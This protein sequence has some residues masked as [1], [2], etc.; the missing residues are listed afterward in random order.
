MNHFSWIDYTIFGVYLAI[1][2]G[3]GLFA[4]RGPKTSLGEYFLAGRGMNSV[5]VAMSILAALFS[6]ISY[7]AGPAE[8]YRN[9]FGFAYAMLAFFIATPFTAIWM[10]PKFYQSR[11]FTAYQ[12]L[13]ERFSLSA[14][15]LAS[16]LFIFRVVLWLAAATYAPA[17]ALEKVTGLPLWV[18]I[19]S[20]GAITTTYTAL[21]GMRAVIWTDLMQL[22]VLF[23]GQLIIVIVALGKI[24]G[25]FGGMWETVVAD[26]R[27]DLSLSFSLSERVNLGGVLIAAGFLHLVQMATD[28]VSVQR[29]LTAGSLKDSQR[30]LWIKLWSVP[31]VLALFYGTGLVLYA[32]YKVHGDPIAAGLIEKPDQ[33]L[34]YFV[35]TQ[36]PAGLPG[37]L[38]AAI[39]AA[40]M[41]VISSGL[42]SL[43]SATVVDFQQRLSGVKDGSASTQVSNARRITVGYGIL[44]MLLAFAVAKMPGNLVESVNTIIGLIGG[45][46]LGLFFLGMF[47]K[48]ATTRGALT[49]CFAGFVGILS[50]YLYQNGIFTA[51]KPEQLVSFLWFTLLGCLLTMI[52][53]LACSRGPAKEHASA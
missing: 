49:G 47:T 32:F 33:I 45:P 36:L 16:G 18:T 51:Q 11:Y 50:L 40:S 9:G 17:L 38:I 39:Y 35:V 4:A 15:L 7:L 31:V 48:R 53:G 34:P 14:R 42:N 27:M 20:F 2:V 5:L 10:L 30:S 52:V 25:G 19:L 21:G 44:V 41:S 28:Q 37:L 1:S 3:V 24:P 8:V 29:Y 43:A 26:G 6:G 13:E 12:I 22:C 46:L 23:G